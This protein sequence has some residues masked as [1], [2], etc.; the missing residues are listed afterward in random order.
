[1]LNDIKIQGYLGRDPELSERQGQNGPY[2]S[3]SFSMGVGRD[4]GDGTDWFRC[5]M[6]GKRAEVIDKY[7]RKGSEIIVSGRMESYKPKNDPERTAWI[8][9]VS[10]FW[11][12]RNGN[13][14]GSTG[15]SAAATQDAPVPDGFE[16]L[17][18]DIPF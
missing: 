8:V 15:S 1:M 16:Q 2:K 14:S 4:F 11:F 10:D 5:I 12:T 9:K 17:E 18:E 6:N 3:V 7:F 13:N